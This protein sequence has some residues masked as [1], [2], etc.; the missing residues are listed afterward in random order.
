MN[1]SHPDTVLLA[2]LE[3]LLAARRIADQERLVD[4]AWLA[5]ARAGDFD[6]EPA[7]PE[8]PQPWSAER[9]TDQPPTTGSRGADDAHEAA[10]PVRAR[11]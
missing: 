9:A 5:A 6:L 1:Y 4:E 11:R 7:Q 8:P 3:D 2:E 10:A